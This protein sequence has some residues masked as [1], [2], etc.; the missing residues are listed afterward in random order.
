MWDFLH[1]KPIA[2]CKTVGEINKALK[3]IPEDLP[4][5]SLDFGEPLDYVHISC[6]Q[7]EET[8]KTIILF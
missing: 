8:H 7:D 4:V 2:R 3:F 5:H 1:E 6:A